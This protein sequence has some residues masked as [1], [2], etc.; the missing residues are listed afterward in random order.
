MQ[1]AASCRDH[2]LRH[3]S[4]AEVP[5]IVL[6]PG[7]VSRPRIA[8]TTWGAVPPDVRSP[9]IAFVGLMWYLRRTIRPRTDGSR[10]EQYAALLQG[11]GSPWNATVLEPMS[12]EPAVKLAGYSM[13]VWWLGTQLLAAQTFMSL[14]EAA[15]PSRAFCGVQAGKTARQ[16]VGHALATRRGTTLVGTVRRIDVCIA[17]DTAIAKNR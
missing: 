17:S 4:T 15:R 10:S 7:R 13:V 12:P 5:A 6:T 11:D 14:P 1:D 3:T 2:G 8:W 9:N 16:A